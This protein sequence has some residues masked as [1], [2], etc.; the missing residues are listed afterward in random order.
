MP[1]DIKNLSFELEHELDAM[2]VNLLT[3][4]D[5][6]VLLSQLLDDM[7]KA[8]YLGEE[9]AYYPENHRT[10][11][12]LW[13]LIRHTL[14]DLNLQVEELDKIAASIRQQALNQVDTQIESRNA[15]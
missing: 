7:D 14:S 11:R 10:V 1:A 12:V 6:E 15:V 3:L 4:Q 5:T 8:V 2:S 9:K 13:N